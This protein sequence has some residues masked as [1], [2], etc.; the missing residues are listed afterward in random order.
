MFD[1]SSSIP[2]YRQVQHDILEKIQNGEFQV[3]DRIYTE[4]EIC[5]KY[6]VS[7]ITA[8]RALNELANNNYITR[9]PGKGSFVSMRNPISHNL[10]GFY[11]FADEMKQKGLV[12]SNEV[13]FLGEVDT[14]PEVSEFFSIPKESKSFYIQRLRIANDEIIALDHS[15]FPVYM[16]NWIDEEKLEKVGSIYSILKQNGVTP[17]RALESFE[18]TLL[19]EEEAKLLKIKENTAVMKVNRLTYSNE[20]PIEYNFRYYVPEHFVY[21]IEL[22][23]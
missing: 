12:A 4:K 20:T 5:E 2:K 1:L 21:K 16:K 19:K 6:N 3:G 13:I 10:K 23:L 15:Y 7:S 11:S 17:N 9:Y 22:V 18:A 14:P 8:R